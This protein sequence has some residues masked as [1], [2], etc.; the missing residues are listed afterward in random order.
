[1]KASLVKDVAEKY[2]EVQHLFTSK[3]R[4]HVAA[5]AKLPPDRQMP[6]KRN[7]PRDR[8]VNS[9]N[10]TSVIKKRHTAYN[11]WLKAEGLQYP[12]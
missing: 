9:T 4:E 5:N 7:A 11:D 3:D 10:L 2:R 12:E 6:T 8:L 1:M